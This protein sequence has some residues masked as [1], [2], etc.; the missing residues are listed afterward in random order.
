MKI[1]TAGTVSGL[2]AAVLTGVAFAQ[3][4]HVPDQVMADSVAG[5]A[6]PPVRAAAEEM[7]ARLAAYHDGCRT[8]N[9][10]LRVVYFHPSDLATQKDYAARIDRIMK[11][12]QAFVQDGMERNGFGPLTFP[13]EMKDGRV[14]IHTVQGREPAEA[15]DY[16]KLKGAAGRK[17]RQEIATALADRFDLE[18]S[19]SIVF[20]GLVVRDEDGTYEFSAPYYGAGGS[21]QR[22]GLCH[23]ADCEKL[24]TRFLD[25]S[26]VKTRFRY[27]EHTG[28]FRQNLA[29]FNSKY[30]GGVAH[31]LGHA[32]GL[33]HNGENADERKALGAALMGSGNHSFRRERWSD[34]KGTFL[35]MASATRLA[36]HPLFTGSNH[37]RSERSMARVSDLQF[38][39]DGMELLV[40]GR[41]DGTIPVYAVVAY[42]DPPGRSDYDARTGVGAVC[43]GRFSLR[44]PCA[45]GT[46]QSLRLI[47]C[48]V[49]G[50]VSE[51]QRCPLRVG[52]RGPDVDALNARAVVASCEDLYL[53]GRTGEAVELARHLLADD[54]TPGAA[55][56]ELKHLVALSDPSPEPVPPAEAPARELY[57]SDAAWVSARVGWGKPARNKYYHDERIRDALLLETGGTFHAKGL[58]AHAPSRYV[59]DLDGNWKTFSAAGGLQS[60]VPDVGS[61]VFVVKGDGRE[62]Y[63][64]G[65][66]KGET[67][68]EIRAS[69]KGVKRLELIVE[70]GKGDNACC[71][72]VW[73]SPEL[74]R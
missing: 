32:L 43:E 53:S 67:V 59:F 5:H 15:Y 25:R 48:H 30:I 60:G 45:R 22:F 57:L 46:K 42:A 17:A 65:L 24:D 11:D 4:G 41:V 33:P 28:S 26:H 51:V 36:S 14:V 62:L 50:A 8:S 9:G 2:V 34:R 69:V 23:V 19:F 66:L 49:N 63:R 74:S 13:M 52:F 71:W 35:T 7:L 38:A 73:G 61:A 56:P 37:G 64:S 20:H 55:G 10:V 16:R 68:A 6:S 27:R 29:D 70:S 44:I 40:E 1:R 31:E 12:I 54:S 3:A 39:R 21:N 72:S 47:V 18:R 58:Y